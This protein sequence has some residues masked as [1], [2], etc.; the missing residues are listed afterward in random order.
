MAIVIPNN[1]QIWRA[2]RYLHLGYS[3]ERVAEIVGCDLVY[4]QWRKAGY[5]VEQLRPSLKKEKG[6]PLHG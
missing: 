2:D 6:I 3:A 4:V 5:R 1:D